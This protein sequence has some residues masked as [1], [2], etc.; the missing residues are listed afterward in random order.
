MALNF[1]ISNVAAKAL[2]DSFDDQVNIGSTAAVTD[3]RSGAQPADPDTAA[4]GTLLAT[5]T[6]SDPAFGAATDANPGG[7]LTASTITGDSTTS[8]NRPMTKSKTDFS[9]RYQRACGAKV[10]RGC[11]M[12]KLWCFMA[13]PSALPLRM[14]L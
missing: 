4:T 2:A 11:N 12:G 13:S 1:R 8:S 10:E 5:L 3:I 9:G 7:L 6:F 14:Q